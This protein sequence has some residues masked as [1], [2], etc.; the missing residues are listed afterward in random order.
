M[1]VIKF[2]YNGIKIDG[3]LVKGFWSKGGYTN[4]AKYC[5]YADSYCSRLLREH[6]M[7]ENSTDITTDYFEEDKVYFFDGNLEVDNAFKQQEI[8]N[9][10]RALK[11]LEKQK[12]L[13]PDYFE[14]YYKTD[15][16]KYKEIVNEAR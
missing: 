11:R 16:E 2:M 13:R 7:V 12:E 14:R 15:Y 6:F 4:G 1:A 3:K 5:F 8:K 10:K 9:A